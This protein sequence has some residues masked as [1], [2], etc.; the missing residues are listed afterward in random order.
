MLRVASV[1]CM[2]R[3]VGRAAGEGGEGVKPV[4]V[5]VP[6]VAVAVAVG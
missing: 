1:L 6:V 2:L 3:T 5:F 4:P